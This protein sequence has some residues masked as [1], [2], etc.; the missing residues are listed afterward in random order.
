MGYMFKY[1][2]DWRY[3]SLI[4]ERRPSGVTKGHKRML[5]DF[6]PAKNGEN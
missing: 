2:K 5:R 1:S 6:S 3:G 4:Q